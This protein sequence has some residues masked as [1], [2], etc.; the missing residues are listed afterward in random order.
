MNKNF[1]HNKFS[2]KTFSEFK[3]SVQCFGPIKKRFTKGKIE[4]AFINEL[5]L[6][7][8]GFKRKIEYF[9]IELKLRLPNFASLRQKCNY[10][11][12]QSFI[13]F[14]IVVLQSFFFNETLIVQKKKKTNMI[15]FKLFYF[16]WFKLKKNKNY[17]KGRILNAIKGGFAVGFVGY[18]AFLPK[19]HSL[20]AHVG[21]YNVFYI[22]AVNLEKQTFIVSQKRIDKIVKRRLLKFGSKLIYLKEKQQKH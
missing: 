14:N 10:I 13:N 20:H 5:L 22:I 1:K 9:A 21:C 19:S 6:V 18:I 15:K 17:I 8:F 2:K 11:Q 3:K 16:L 12:K 4:V 7:D